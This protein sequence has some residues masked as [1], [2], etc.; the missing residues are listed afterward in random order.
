MVTVIVDQRELRSSVAKELE[1]LNCSLVF[2]TL[3]VADY[4]VSEKVAFERKTAEDFL[5]S[6][7]DEKKLFGQI[8]DLCDAYGRPILIVEGGIDDLFTLRRVHPNSV[9]GVLNTLAASFRCPVLYTLNS[10]ETASVIAAIAL[11]EQ[12]LERR[13]IILHG[14]RSSLSPSELKEYVVSAIPDIGPVVSQNILR[15]FR[16]IQA[17]F[18][19]PEE[20]LMK[21]DLVGPETAKRIREVVGG[22]YVEQEDRL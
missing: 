13:P 12:E 2:K 16:T 1:K 7:L 5:K 8:S 11:R 9:Q 17:A 19:A 6:W 10:A 22:E 15:H 4:V 20:E 3:E 14:K 21:V 18:S